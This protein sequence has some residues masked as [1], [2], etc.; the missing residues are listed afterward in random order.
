MMIYLFNASLGLSK[1][2]L[3]QPFEQEDVHSCSPHMSMQLIPDS[4]W[5]QS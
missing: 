2:K 4:D 5:I 1:Y 3:L